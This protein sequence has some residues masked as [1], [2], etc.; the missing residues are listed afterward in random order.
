MAANRFRD[1]SGIYWI[2]K[3]KLV[4]QVEKD[5][6]MII[7]LV[8]KIIGHNLTEAGS[9]P[10]TGRHYDYCE[11]CHGMVPRPIIEKKDE[12]MTDEVW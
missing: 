2:R 9:C 8:C 3:A 6:G 1:W 4:W 10:F 7:R 12:F 11:R 5:Q